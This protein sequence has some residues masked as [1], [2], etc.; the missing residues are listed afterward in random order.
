MAQG[1]KAGFWKVLAVIL[2]GV[3]AVV[4][5]LGGA[6][7]SCVA[8]NPNGF[9]A[10]MAKLAPFQLVFQMLVVVSLAAGI[11]GTL[12][13]FWLAKGKG[14]AYLYSLVF[15]AVGLV[16]SGIQFYFSATYRGSTAPNNMRLY[17]TALTLLVFLLLR[18]PGIWQKAGLESRSSA[19]GG[20]APAGGAA[21]FLAGL[22][23]LTVPLWAAPT[24]FFNGYNTAAEW[25]VPTLAIG[26]LMMASGAGLFI[27]KASP[28]EFGS[29]LS[30]GNSR[31]TAGSTPLRQRLPKS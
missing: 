6:G 12:V 15:L 25:L 21:L 23:T 24:H 13:T 7:T 31:A 10:S 14:R 1:K 19:P 9:G 5:I 2:L 18:L 22:I 4:T 20:A 26:T 11:F 30:K 8:L 3:T 17:L 27:Y 16:S 29:F 28:L